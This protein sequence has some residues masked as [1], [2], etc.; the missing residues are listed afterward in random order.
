MSDE[1]QPES[2][3]QP[4][5]KRPRWTGRTREPQRFRERILSHL[6]AQ[7][8]PRTRYVDATYRQNAW[9]TWHILKHLWAGETFCYEC[10]YFIPASLF[11]APLS[12]LTERKGRD[13]ASV[14]GVSAGGVVV[15]TEKVGRDSLP[16]S[17]ASARKHAP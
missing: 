14:N 3:A 13:G 5:A 17:A 10:S 4:A 15:P 12:T 1:V 16:Q 2:V 6:R 8:R 7:T 9:E 11:P